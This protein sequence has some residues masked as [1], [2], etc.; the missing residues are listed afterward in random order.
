[1]SPTKKGKKRGKTSRHLG[2]PLLKA[3]AVS[4]GLS[5]FGPMSLPFPNVVW[6]AFP[7]DSHN[8]GNFKINANYLPTV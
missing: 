5:L 4:S 8:F 1:M 6:L 7:V 2:F 3:F